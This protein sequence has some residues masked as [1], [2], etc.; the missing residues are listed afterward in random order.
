MIDQLIVILPWRQAPSLMT[1][2]RKAM[3]A[4]NGAP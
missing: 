4:P 1:P 3:A 2:A